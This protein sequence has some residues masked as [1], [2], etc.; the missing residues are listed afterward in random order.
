MITIKTQSEIELMRASNELVS[1]TLSEV[2]QLIQPGFT[3]IELDQLAEQ[4]IRDNGGV[5]V[6]KGYG[7]F[8]ASLCISINDCVV[9]GIPSKYEIKETDIVS[10]DCGVLMNGFV[11]DAAYTFALKE[12]KEETLKLLKVTKQSLSYGIEQARVGNR[13]GDI[14]Y[15]IQDY[16][17]R[18]HGY[19]VV[20][21]LV[22]HG[23]GK[24]LHEPPEIPNFGRRGRG[25]K[26][27]E[28]M[29]IAIE[30]MINMGTKKVR[31]HEDGWSILTRD[32]LPSAHYEHSIAIR[33]KGP[34]ILSN[35]QIIE[36]KVK[37]NSNLIDI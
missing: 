4:V 28:G 1:I 6:F 35:H 33:Q 11:G 17:E 36:D 9:H 31:Q 16:T 23:V 12:V 29:T 19:G 13:V 22:G 15:A 8:P 5:P 30:P 26:L 32:G 10:V 2:A 24:A 27:K 25:L 3:G 7:G 34:D 21:A 20:R 14:G 37:N 18:Q